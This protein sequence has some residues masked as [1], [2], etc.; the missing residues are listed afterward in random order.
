[1]KKQTASSSFESQ[2][3]V[4]ISEDNNHNRFLQTLYVE[5]VP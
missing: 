1:M 3:A 4:S 5:D 2:V